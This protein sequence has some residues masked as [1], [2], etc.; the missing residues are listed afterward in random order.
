M[1]IAVAQKAFSK[2]G[3]LDRI[4]VFLPAHDDRDWETI[5]SGSIPAGVTLNPQGSRTDE[6][7]KMMRAFRWNIRV[8]SYISLVVGAFLI[9]NTIAIS[10]VRRRTEIG[11]MR[12]LGAGR[13][14]VTLIYLS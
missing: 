8:L 14:A 10:V 5:I 13:A 11:V 1:D 3:R 6:N 7:R 4:E 9:Y 12:A 2:R